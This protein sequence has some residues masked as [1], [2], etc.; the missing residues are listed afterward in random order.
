MTDL[1][2]QYANTAGEALA[3]ILIA[4]LGD[5]PD[6]TVVDGI[7]EL[8]NQVDAYFAR[9]TGTIVVDFNNDG[10]TATFP[11]QMGKPKDERTLAG[12]FTSLR[13]ISATDEV[14]VCKG[15]RWQKPV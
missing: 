11:T 9:S 12:K 15:M 6:G 4:R 3:G 13:T 8:G 5:N 2:L 7:Y 14:V 10:L 1:A